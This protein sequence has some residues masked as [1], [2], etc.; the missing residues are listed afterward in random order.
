[1]SAYLP[2]FIAAAAIALT[3]A[4]CVRPMRRGGS[5]HAVGTSSSSARLAEELEL[6]RTELELLRLQQGTPPP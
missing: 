2:A 1:M 6:A 3:Y 5:C 4:F